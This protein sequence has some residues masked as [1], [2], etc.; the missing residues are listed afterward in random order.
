MMQH[1]DLQKEGFHIHFDSQVVQ[2]HPVGVSSIV[3]LSILLCY[4]LLQIYNT[5]CPEKLRP[6]CGATEEEL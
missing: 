4:L 2:Y 6:I 5:R 3:K 1:V